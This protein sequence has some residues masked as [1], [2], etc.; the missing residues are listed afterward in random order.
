[1]TVALFAP[2]FVDQFAPRA[3]VATLRL[4]EALGVDVAV[5]DGAACCGQPT[6]NAG[7]AR[8]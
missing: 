3:A 7:I 1:M 8:A 6:A 5:P 4:L 2:C